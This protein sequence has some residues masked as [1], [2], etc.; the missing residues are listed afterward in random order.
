MQTRESIFFDIWLKLVIS[1]V[2]AKAESSISRHRSK[3]G[4]QFWMRTY[5]RLI[6]MHYVQHLIRNQKSPPQPNSCSN[7]ATSESQMPKVPM[8]FSA[9]SWRSCAT[10]ES[11]KPE[12]HLKCN[13]RSWRSC[14]RR[15]SPKFEMHLKCNAR[16][17]MSKSIPESFALWWMRIGRR[18]IMQKFIW[19]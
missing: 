17:W 12:M 5:C 9:K 16:S 8:K 7:N 15:E 2:L 11:Q 13:A 14:K 6:S 1:L 3:P 10:S 4:S 18:I 19:F